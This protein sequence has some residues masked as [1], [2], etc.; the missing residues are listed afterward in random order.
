MVPDN[1]KHCSPP[2]AIE[3][4]EMTIAVLGWLGQHKETYE[5]D[6]DNGIMAAFDQLWPCH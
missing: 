3:T 5:L 4:K 6:T 1:S 2:D